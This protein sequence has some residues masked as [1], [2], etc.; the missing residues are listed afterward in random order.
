M[1]CLTTAVSNG[2]FYVIFLKFATKIDKAEFLY[3]SRYIE[4]ID[5]IP[6]DPLRFITN[7]ARL[8]ISLIQ[9]V[10]HRLPYK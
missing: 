10:S 8:V 4:T 1:N 7:R 2:V 9:F 6:F 3:L 5:K